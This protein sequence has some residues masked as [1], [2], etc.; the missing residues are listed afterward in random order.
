MT[1]EVIEGPF[2]YLFA[3]AVELLQRFFQEEGFETPS[4][5]IGERAATMAASESHWLAVALADGQP[6]GVATAC[7]FF[8]IEAGGFVELEDLYVLPAFRNCGVARRLI[9]AAARWSESKGA[10]L[11]EVVITPDGQ[12]RHGLDR[13]YV[14]LGFKRTGRTILIR[15]LGQD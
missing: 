10:G 14:N 15:D 12:Q 11:L 8:T 6:V 9:E 2:H 4:R 3:G 13:F 1:I 5:L 7:L